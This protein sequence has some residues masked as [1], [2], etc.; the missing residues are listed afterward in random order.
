MQAKGKNLELSASWQLPQP[1]R[2]HCRYRSMERFLG[3]LDP[4]LTSLRHLGTQIAI[5]EEVEYCCSICNW[6]VVSTA[7]PAVWRFPA[8]IFP[9]QCLYSQY[10][11]IILQR[12]TG[13]ISGQH[14]RFYAGRSMGV[15]EDRME[16]P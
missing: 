3:F 14:L 2:K 16:G 12:S 6:S 1:K 7:L 15:S 4:C 5:D 8:L 10:H 9:P 13:K 11:Q